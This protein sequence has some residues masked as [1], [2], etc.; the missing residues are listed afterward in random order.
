MNKQDKNYI[1]R[2]L[3]LLKGTAKELKDEFKIN[4]NKL[5]EE[6]YLEIECYTD[7]INSRIKLIER[8]K[9]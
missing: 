4:K 8:R 2:R 9:K 6:L 1:E 5:L 3:N 7:E